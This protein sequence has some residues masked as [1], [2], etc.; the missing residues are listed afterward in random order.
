MQLLPLIVFALVFAAALTTIGARGETLIAF[1]D[2]LNETMMKSSSG[3]CTWHR[4][5]SSHWSPRNSA[6]PVGRRLSRADLAV[7]RY[8]GTVLLGLAL[9]FAVLLA[10]L[11]LVA[12]RGLDYLRTVL[13]ALVTAFGT[14][15]STATPPLS[16]ECVREAG[17][18]D[19]AVRFVLPWVQ[20]STWT[21][22]RSTRRS[23]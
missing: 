14:A 22:R 18:D 13:R 21:A 7:G 19:R 6:R 4:S 23:Q 17:A 5:A 3:S 9:H 12:G 16:M 1:F 10:V 2:G 20:P 15:S 11:L 8:V